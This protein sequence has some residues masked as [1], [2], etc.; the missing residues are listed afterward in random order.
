MCA[1]LKTTWKALEES[2]NLRSRLAIAE[3]RLPLLQLIQVH[4]SAAAF[5]L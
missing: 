2:R 4:I 1:N 3:P 5:Q